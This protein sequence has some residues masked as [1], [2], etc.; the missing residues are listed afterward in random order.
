MAA[1]NTRMGTRWRLLFVSTVLHLLIAG[2]VSA[3]TVLVRHAEAGSGL[4]LFVNDTSTATAT[5]DPSGNTLLKGNLSGDRTIDALVAVDSCSGR[6][7]V[8]VYDRSTAPPA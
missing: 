4:E 2:A 5:A 8:L 3:Q 6:R 1:K 7:R